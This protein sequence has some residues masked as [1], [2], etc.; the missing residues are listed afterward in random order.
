MKVSQ[1]I[2]AR[3]VTTVYYGWNNELQLT[4]DGG[5]VNLK[6]NSASLRDIAKVLNEKIAEEDEEARKEKEEQE[7]EQE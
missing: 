5:Q 7:V 4:V 1:V 6:L 2:E 3:N